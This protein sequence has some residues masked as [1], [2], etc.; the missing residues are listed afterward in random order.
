MYL[1]TM[2]IYI[3]SQPNR[4]ES[5]NF[6]Y[7]QNDIQLEF[8]DF[9]KVPDSADLKMFETY[10][11]KS[12]VNVQIH[13]VLDYPK[14]ARKIKTLKEQ[15]YIAPTF[16]KKC[17]P[18]IEEDSTELK[19][20]QIY[21]DIAE[22]CARLTRIKIN[23]IEKLDMGNGFVAAN[24]PSRI[25]EMYKLMGEMF[26]SFGKQVLVDKKEGALENWRKSVDEM[27]KSTEDYSTSANE[28]NRFIN[29]QPYSDEYKISYE[30]YGRRL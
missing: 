24:F 10:S 29:N 27:L 14:K 20:A 11:L 16:C 6:L 21:F 9:E 7:W 17:S 4:L 12:A 1:I 22:Y 23:E 19:I 8:A 15:W 28:C 30:K 26:G 5:I 18:L 3:Q 2:F 25:E 13:A